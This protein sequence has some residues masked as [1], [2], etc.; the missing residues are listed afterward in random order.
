MILSQGQSLTLLDLK[1]NDIT[2]EGAMILG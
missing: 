2:P 1:N